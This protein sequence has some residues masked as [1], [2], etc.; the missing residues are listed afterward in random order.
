[1]IHSSHFPTSQSSFETKPLLA[2]MTNNAFMRFE[3]SKRLCFLVSVGIL[4]LV[5]LLP[6]KTFLSAFQSGVIRNIMSEINADVDELIVSEGIGIYGTN[7]LQMYLLAKLFE[8]LSTCEGSSSDSSEVHALVDFLFSSKYQVNIIP[9]G[10]RSKVCS[11][12][13]IYSHW[14]TVVLPALSFRWDDVEMQWLSLIGLQALYHSFIM[15]TCNNVDK[16]SFNRT[17][18]K[19][20]AMMHLTTI[21]AWG[22]KNITTAWKGILVLSWKHLSVG[23]DAEGKDIICM[24]IEGSDMPC[25]DSKQKEVRELLPIPDHGVESVECSEVQRITD[26]IDDSNDVVGV[27]EPI[28]LVD[29]Q[30]PPANNCFSFGDDLVRDLKSCLIPC[31]DDLSSRQVR[32]SSSID[33]D[34]CLLTS[35]IITLLAYTTGFRSRYYWRCS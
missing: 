8:Y 1:M 10:S 31:E 4:K 11:S 27:V 30:S 29:I 26:E 5:D 32:S 24:Q 22:D 20:T 18:L 28:A 12:T 25:E 16:E 34:P 17:D 7:K 23:Y 35:V 9:V 6:V 15:G 14:K 13:D 33:L 19:D 3:Q 21:G 2:F